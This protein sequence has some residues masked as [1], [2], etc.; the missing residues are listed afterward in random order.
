MQLTLLHCQSRIVWR[1]R[2]HRLEKLGAQIDESTIV[3]CER[4]C[5]VS[6]S[7]EFHGRNQESKI[8]GL[9]E[10]VEVPVAQTS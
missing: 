7:L 10:P 6:G 5:G 2:S 1:L 8:P 4:I 9:P 3:Q